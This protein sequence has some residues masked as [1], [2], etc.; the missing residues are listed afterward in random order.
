[1]GTATTAP[2]T[3]APTGTTEPGPRPS[4]RPSQPPGPSATP[5]FHP[6][7]TADIGWAPAMRQV[8]VKLLSPAKAAP[9]KPVRPARPGSGPTEASTHLSRK[10]D[11][12]EQQV[13]SLISS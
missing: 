11:G 10:D 12:M 5:P 4:G 1:M 13:T 7:Q 6:G 8:V 2:T 3:L 9:T